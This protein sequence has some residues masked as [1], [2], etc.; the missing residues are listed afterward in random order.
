MSSKRPNHEVSDG[1]V[2]ADLGLPQPERRLAKAELVHQIGVLIR[3]RGLT[4]KCAA[5]ILGIPQPRVS[6]LL[7]GD[8]SGFSMDKLLQLLNAL[9]QD[10][11][12]IVRP[13][14]RSRDHALV[15][16]TAI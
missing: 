5:E 13:R 16:V 11:E 14:P 2:F 4:Q 10:I 8:L 1:N 15:H 12:I 9:D 7:R 6:K 3:E